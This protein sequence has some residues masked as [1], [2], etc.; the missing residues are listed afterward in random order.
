MRV[1]VDR[2]TGRPGHQTHPRDRFTGGAARSAARFAEQLDQLFGGARETSL[3][4]CRVRCRRDPPRPAT[5]RRVRAPSRRTNRPRG[6]APS[7]R[8]VWD[9]VVPNSWQNPADTG[10]LRSNTPHAALLFPANQLDRQR[11]VRASREVAGSNP[12][13]PCMYVRRPREHGAFVM[14]RHVAGRLDGNDGSRME[15]PHL[16]C[17]RRAAF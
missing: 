10:C 12:P 13:R 15:A 17:H 1:N 8:E 3:R 9:N 14:S 16:R 2:P 5:P 4:R 7:S 11:L 6:K